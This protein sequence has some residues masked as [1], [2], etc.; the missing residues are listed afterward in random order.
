MLYRDQRQPFGVN[1]IRGFQE[2][3]SLEERRLKDDGIVGR[4]LVENGS[5]I[6]NFECIPISSINAEKYEVACLD[7]TYHIMDSDINGNGMVVVWR[8]VV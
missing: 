5:L 7:E 8:S 1:R 6:G 3:P 4:Y 2:L